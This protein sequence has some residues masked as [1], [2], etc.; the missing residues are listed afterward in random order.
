MH[1][2]QRGL[3]LIQVA[4]VMAT[5]AAIAMAAMMSMRSERNLFAEALGKLTGHPLAPA[6]GAVPG[7]AADAAAAQLARPARP[8]GVLRKCVID[9]KTV[10][11]DV[12]CTDANATSTVVKVHE[13]RGIE[14]PKVPKAEPA[15]D[16]APTALDKAI[17]KATR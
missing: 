2:Y 5:L 10:F 4:I 7:S 12:D 6:P 1:R 15:A 9:G 17:E 11:S 13:T 16:S 8:A 3:G 14:S